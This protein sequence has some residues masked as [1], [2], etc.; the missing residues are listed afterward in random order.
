VALLAEASLPDPCFW[1]PRQPYQYKVE[2]ELRR[3][4]QCLATTERR[5]AIRPLGVRARKLLLE[6]KTWV[7]RGVCYD[8]V[9]G[10]EVA[11][12]RHAGAAMS[13]DR[14]IPKLFEDA[15]HQGGLIAAEIKG[16]R[17]ALREQLHRLKHFQAVGVVVVESPETPGDTLHK[18][19]RNVLLAQV[20]S[21]GAASPP[22]L[23]ADLMVCDIA[24]PIRL[25]AWLENLPVPVIAR[26]RAGVQVDLAAGRSQ[27]DALQRVLAGRGDFAGYIV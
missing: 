7:V 23:W 16:S 5:L 27:C 10:V 25:P 22:I 2:V 14:V 4:G 19:A 17:E 9:P 12:W 8:E 24:D 21:T 20:C 6:G 3:S 15:A 11:E 1:T 13:I 26:R 18:A